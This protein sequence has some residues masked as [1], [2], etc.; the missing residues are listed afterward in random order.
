MSKCVYVFKKKSSIILVQLQEKVELND[1]VQAA[2]LIRN[3][4]IFPITDYLFK[5]AVGEQFHGTGTVLN[6][7]MRSL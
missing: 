3:L 7:A 2:T 6:R 5:Q 1:Y 4:L